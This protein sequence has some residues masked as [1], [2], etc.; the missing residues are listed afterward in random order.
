MKAADSPQQVVIMAGGL[1]TRL[2]A[3][4]AHTPK[5]LQHVAGKPFVDRLLHFLAAQGYRNYVFCL[6]HQ[7][8]LVS[9]YL[10][11]HFRHLNVVV[12]LDDEPRGTGKALI[13]A[14]HL[15][16]GMFTVVMGDTYF[17]FM[18]H[19]LWRLAGIRDAGA[20]A[21]SDHLFDQVGNVELSGNDVTRYHAVPRPG[22]RY[23]DAGTLVLRRGTL[24][25]GPW[26][27]VDRL[28]LGDVLQSLV[29]QRQL[30]ALRVDSP[31][32]DIGTP[33]RRDRLSMLFNSRGQ[34]HEHPTC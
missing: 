17:P 25:H 1:G 5:V 32:Y 6:A 34:P 31:F 4:S 3:E 13:N 20:M 23:A 30:R 28:D 10:R 8:E 7:G 22:L 26:Q 18:H 16:D 15:L 14:Q 24:D 11:Q 9:S 33:A 19:R 21:V 12:H 27:S 29:R 2:G